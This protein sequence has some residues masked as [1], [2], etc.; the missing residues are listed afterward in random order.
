MAYRRSRIRQGG[1][2]PRR[3]KPSMAEPDDC[4]ARLE[5]WLIEFDKRQSDRFAA[6]NTRIDDL[7]YDMSAR[8]ATIEVRNTSIFGSAGKRS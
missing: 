4:L 1:R 3:R 7:R 2:R 6:L 8:F 5:V